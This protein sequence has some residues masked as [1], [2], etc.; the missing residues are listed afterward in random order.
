MPLLSAFAPLGMLAMSSAPSHA[1]RFYDAM[2]ADITN[3]A[4]GKPAM[5]VTSGSRM[6]G[7]IY[8]AAMQMAR[9]RYALEHAGAEIRPTCV[10]ESIA[11]RED[12]YG[13]APTDGDNLKTRRAVLA[14]RRLLPLGCAQT[15]VESALIEL[16][17]EDFLA[18]LPTPLEDKVNWPLAIADQ[19]MNLQRADIPNVLLRTVDS[20]SGGVPGSLTIRYDALD[21]ATTVTSL[22]VGIGD[23]VVVDAGNPDFAEVVTVT[24]TDIV[25]GSPAYRTLTG[26]FTQPHPAGAVCVVG[27]WPYWHS[28]KRTSLVILAEAAA[29]DQET[30]RKVNDLMGRM[31]REVSRWAIAGGS[32][33][34]GVGGSAGP[35]KIGVGKIGVTPLGTVDF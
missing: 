29:E 33:S 8:A 22:R 3:P 16:L 20:V 27:D 25:A 2:V 24:D 26:V 7:F 34:Y 13:A 21:P 10:T 5:A 4:D 6:D 15:N 28:T 14:A 35:F 1:E 11:K 18:Y 32:G 31:A 23:K 17:G 9:A 12:E 30:R 19:P